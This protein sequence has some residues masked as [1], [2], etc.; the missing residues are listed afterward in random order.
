MDKLNEMGRLAKMGA[1]GALIQA[2]KVDDD[3]AQ[4]CQNLGMEIINTVRNM[5]YA[6]P[7]KQGEK[8]V[9]ARKRV[10]ALAIELLETE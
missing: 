9:Q 2:P 8:Y 3:N 6:L 10:L 5:S 1:T 7:E 4:L